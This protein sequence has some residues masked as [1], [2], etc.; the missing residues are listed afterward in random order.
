MKCEYCSNPATVH[1][2]KVINK[3]ISE[4]HL[5]EEC[6]RE[7]NLI[8]N[9]PQDLNV[10]AVL[11]LVFGAICPKPLGRIRTIPFV[12]SAAHRTLTFAR[13]DAWAVRTI[14]MAFRSMLEP[15]LE[16]VQCGAVRHIGKTPQRHRKRMNQADLGELEAKLK[17]AVESEQYEE[18]AK[19][20]D[21]I[22]ALGSDDEL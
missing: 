17:L 1:L 11:E 3:H 22:R 18:A 13:K 12:P 6:A 16:R 9:A 2:T 21:A 8:P 14:T 4:I 7:K 10:P 19:L 5:C 20:R 15:V